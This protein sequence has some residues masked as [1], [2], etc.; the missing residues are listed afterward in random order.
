[1]LRTHVADPG[2][3]PGIFSVLSAD[4]PVKDFDVKRHRYSGGS[5]EILEPVRN[6]D[7]SC[8]KDRE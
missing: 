6:L 8:A 3:V 5:W 4:G 1:M 7:G 2:R